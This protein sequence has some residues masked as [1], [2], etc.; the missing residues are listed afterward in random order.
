M[1]VVVNEKKQWN[2]ELR[3]GFVFGSTE[4]IYNP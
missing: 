2:S 4:D 3:G 1:I